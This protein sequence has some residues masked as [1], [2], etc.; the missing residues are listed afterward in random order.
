MPWQQSGKEKQ[1]S[2]QSETETAQTKGYA[3][4][5]KDK[6]GGKVDQVMG[7]AKG[8]QS[9]EAAGKFS[10]LSQIPTFWWVLYYLF[11]GNVRSQKGDTQQDVNK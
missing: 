3:E 10:R 7:A 9:Q 4:G 5:T 6:A 2:G 8:D 11:T 1:A